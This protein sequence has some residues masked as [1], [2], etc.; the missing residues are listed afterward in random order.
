MQNS[1]RLSRTMPAGQQ[2]AA[3]PVFTAS[4]IA[5]ALHLTKRAV[6]RQLEQIAPDAVATVSGNKTNAFEFSTLPAALQVRLAT[7][8]AALHYRGAEQLLS[9]PSP[10][11]QP[12]LPWAQIAPHSQERAHKLR[13]ALARALSMQNTASADELDQVIS[14]D[15]R[16]VFGQALSARNGRR[17]LERTLERAGACADFSRPEIYLDERPAT[18]AAELLPAALH[19]EGLQP[20]QHIVESWRDPHRPTLSER[21]YL[22]TYVIETFDRAL[23]CGMSRK[24]A[25]AEL[26]AFLKAYAPGLARSPAAMDR[27]LRR[28]HSRYVAAGRPALVVHDARQAKSGW[29]RAPELTKE[30][31][32]ALIARAVER[33]GRLAQAWRELRREGKLSAELLAYYP[34]QPHSKSYVPRK[35]SVVLK[36]KIA[37]LFDIHH[38]TKRARLN[39]AFV[40]RRPD[41]CSGEWMQGDDLTAPIYFWETDANGAVRVVRS[42]VLAMIDVR[43]LYVLGFV[44]TGTP[45]YSAFHIRN[46]ISK[47]HDVYGLPRRGFYFENGSWRARIL[48]GSED[49]AE[50][51]NT[52]NGLRGLGIEFR[53]AHLARAKVIERVFGL[54][55]NLMDGLPGY[56]GR[57]ERHDHF[58]RHEKNKRLVESGRAQPQEFFLHRDMWAERLEGI[59][60]AYNDEKQGGKYL[61]DLSPREG[62]EKF[63]AT[64]GALRLPP[65]MRHLVSCYRQ[66]VIIGRNGITFRFGK[67]SYSY[68]NKATG[69]RRGETVLAWF[70]PEKPEVLTVTDAKC[71]NGFCVPR[72]APVSAMDASPE[73]LA[74]ALEMNAQHDSYSK[75]LYRM[76]SPRFSVSFHARQFQHVAVD[77]RTAVTH[78]ALQERRAEFVQAEKDDAAQ[79]TSAVRKAR[80]LGMPAEILNRDASAA[81]AGLGLIEAARREHRNEQA[82]SGPVVTEGGAQGGSGRI[83][84]GF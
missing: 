72:A 47:V 71:G 74:A 53:H 29:R 27:D 26:L 5:D 39:G 56:C 1:S 65:G 22:W 41:F 58:E 66:S 50:W 51:N 78:V 30:D 45:A 67:Q 42:Q 54:A 40:E 3:E 28:K 48:K 43:S 35:I 63:F 20:L 83:L 11:W 84:Q 31:S 17:L 19:A 57:D 55:Q 82:A 32:L 9:A 81:V 7:R 36:P 62:Y 79:R 16:Q 10:Q 13:R 18:A 15:Y 76:I 80:A 12:A 49:A 23:T 75:S 59:F 70:D 38:G 60:N 64:A 14:A 24:A 61:P 8:A 52:E 4:R 44:L 33:G 6:A 46:L 68:R 37:M 73:E 21:N 77:R 69:A 2:S 34:A 25:R